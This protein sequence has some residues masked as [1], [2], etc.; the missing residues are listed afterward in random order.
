MKT[1]KELCWE[2]VPWTLWWSTA[3]GKTGNE[4]W[5]MSSLQQILL[6]H[7][8]LELFSS[9]FLVLRERERFWKLITTKCFDCGKNSCPGIFASTLPWPHVVLQ[10]QKC[11]ALI[12]FLNTVAQLCHNSLKSID[13][14]S[15]MASSQSLWCSS[16]IIACIAYFCHPSPHGIFNLPFIWCY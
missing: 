4:G 7:N 8:L 11:D 15:L 14:P 6:N 16:V 10:M 5:N 1:S 12:E 9:F 3:L 13:N 2:E